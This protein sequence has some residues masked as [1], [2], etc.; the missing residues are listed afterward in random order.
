ML[1]FLFTLAQASILMDPTTRMFVTS[2]GRTIMFH[3]VNVVVKAP[4]YIPITDSFDPQ[5]SLCD[6]DITNLVSWGMNFVR[7][8]VMWEAVET[9]PGYFDQAYLI[10]MNNLIN[11]LGQNGIWTLIDAHQDAY[12]RHICGEGIPN[13]YAANLTDVC[14]GTIGEILQLL[15]KCTPF[16]KFNYTTD[17]DGNPII[18]DCQKV[19]FVEYFYT[20]EAGDGY[21]RIYKNVYNLQDRFNDFW[22][23]TSAFFASNPYVVGYDILNEPLQANMNTEPW[24]MIPGVND[25]INL[26]PLYKRIT[27]TIRENDDE[28]IIF[29]EPIQADLLPHLGGMVFPIGLT[30]TPGNETYNDRQILNDHAYC[31]QGQ[32]DICQYGEPQL[33]DKEFCEELNFARVTSR[34]LDAK[35]LNVGLII[36]EFGACFD[37]QNCVNEI[38]SVTDACDKNLVGWAY[39]MFKGFGDFTTTGGLLEGF[40]NNQ[41]LQVGKVKA[42]ARTYALVYQGVPNLIDFNVETGEFQTNF[43]VKA[44]VNSPTIIF[45]S[46]EFYYKNGVDI[47]VY[48]S[49]DLSY[50]IT[51]LNS[52]YYSVL[53]LNPQISLASINLKAK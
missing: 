36:S 40:Y 4:P 30:E 9:S 23:F 53:F 31:C 26:Q 8:G 37:S 17:P 12:A 50:K 3:G 47:T 24:V 49:I 52:S 33:K 29:F 34:A 25:Y 39:W 20:P 10:K 27:E 35:G 14:S 48:S 2:E 7:L 19:S 18:S 38:F 16:S 11:K 1:I 15:G 28:K 43:T 22:N 13:F 41:T 45:A 44:G 5:M 6:A 21:S 42:L 51:A 46:Q 32:K